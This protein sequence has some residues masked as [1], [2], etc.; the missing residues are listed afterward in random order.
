[1]CS[2]NDTADVIKAKV[3]S[4]LPG[5]ITKYT[6]TDEAILHGHEGGEVEILYTTEYLNIL[7]FTGIPPHELELKIGTPIMLLRNINI[8][9]G[10]CNGT[11]MIVRQLLPKVIEAQIIT[12]T[13]ITLKAY[14]PRILFT[15]K[16]PKLPFIFKRKQ[17]KANRLKQIAMTII[18]SQGQSFKKIRIYL[19]KPVFRHGQLAME[20][21]IDAGT[22]QHDKGKMILMQP[23]ITN[24]SELSSTNYNKTIEAVVYRKWTS[25]TTKTR[26]PTKFC[27]ILIDKQG[28]PIQANIDNWERTLPTETSLIFGRFLQVEEIPNTDFPEHYFNFAAYNELLDWATVRNLIL[29]GDAM[30]AQKSRRVIDIEN[31]RHSDAAIDDPRPAAGSFSMADVRRLSAHVI[32]LRDMPEGVLVLSGLSRVWKSRVCDPV[33]QGADGNGMGEEPHLDVRPTLQRLPFYCTHPTAIDVVIPNPNLEDLAVGTPSSKIL[34]KVEASQK[35]KASTSGATS[36]HVA[37][38]TRSALAESSGSTTRPSLFVGDSDDESDGD[39]DACV[40]I[41]L[42]TPL[43]YAV[44]IPSSGNQDSRGKGIMADDAAAPSVGVSRPRPSS[45][46]IPSFRDVS[47]DAIHTDFFPF[48]AGPYYATY[49]QDDVAG[50]CEFNREEWD[51]PYRPTFGVLTKEVFKDPTVCKTVVDQFPTPG[52]M[53]RVEALSEDQL[54]TNMSVLHYM[55]MS[56]GGE[57]LARY[58]SLLQS[59]HDVYPEEPGEEEKIKSLTKSLYNLHAEVA[60]LSATLNQATMFEAEKDEEILRLKITPSEFASFFRG[61]FQVLVQKFLASDKFSRTKDEFA[62]VLKKMANFMLGAQDRLAEAFP[63]DARVS[64]LT[65]K[66]STMTLASKS[67]EL[68]ANVDLTASA[69]NSEHNEEMVNAEDAVELAE[70]ESGRASSSPNDVVVALSVGEKGDG[71]VPSFTADEE[72]EGRVVCRRTLFALS[73]GQTDCRCV[74]VNPADPESCH[75][76]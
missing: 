60:R 26:T 70:V 17:L 37:K 53:V 41:L 50:N 55:M 33:L 22:S 5:H 48:S 10:L 56:H 64:P 4:I 67:L 52:E 39:D 13:R 24:I 62:T 28:T 31:L 30:T 21:P 40:E 51:A 11:R 8:I 19:P 16:D 12:G 36:S 65:I 32:K 54:T 59:H 57:L 58:R 73:L 38:R 6:R 63:L 66:E 7:N 61:Q 15:M 44:V 35:R 43:R 18:K 25:K 14:I 76:P 49:P 9:G 34:S 68:S 71:L 23:E 1:M 74:V 69:V 45:G 47:G 72:G 2:K 75:P 29:T 46:P 20:L 42:V 3:M 27:C